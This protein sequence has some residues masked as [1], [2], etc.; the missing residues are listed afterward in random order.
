MNTFKSYVIG[1]VSSVVLTL[2]AYFLVDLHVRSSHEWISHPVLI[3]VIIGLALVQL[4]IQL[5]F[6]LHLGQESKPRWN[7]FV[8]LSTFSIILILVVGSLWIMNHLNYN[9][10]SADVNTYMLNQENM[11]AVPPG[12]GR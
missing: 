1:F 5:I 6:F 8:F 4:L 10:M 7:L 11:S 2:L 12:G 3:F 9:M